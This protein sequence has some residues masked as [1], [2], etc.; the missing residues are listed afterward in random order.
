MSS[1]TL[2]T[3]YRWDRATMGKADRAQRGVYAIAVNVAF[4]GVPMADDGTLICPLTGKP[5]NVGDC[6]EVDKV[7]PELG[8][9]PGNIIMVSKAGNQGRSTL[10][11]HYSDLPGLARYVRD[12]ARASAGIAVQRKCDAVPM[13]LAMGRGGFEPAVLAGPYGTA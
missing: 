11:Q 5:F 13:W 9:V 4:T 2:E 7:N 3:V 6:G 1:D 12:V 8:Y 10:Q